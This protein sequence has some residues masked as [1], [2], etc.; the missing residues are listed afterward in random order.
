M[1]STTPPPPPPPPTPGHTSSLGPL[2]PSSGAASPSPTRHQNGT[3]PGGDQS[4][5]NDQLMAA[6]R[7]GIN[8]KPT[9]TNDR[10][11][12][13][14]IQRSNGVLDENGKGSCDSPVTPAD[15]KAIDVM[16]DALQAELRS[17]L[18][19]KIKRQDMEAG[20]GTK[21]EEIER[22]IEATRSEVQ[23]KVNGPSVS[24]VND[25]PRVENPLKTIVDVIDRERGAVFAN[26]QPSP[27]AVKKVN[28]PATRPAANGIALPTKAP[29]SNGKPTAITISP[30]PWKKSVPVSPA[31]VADS[32]K[33]QSVASSSIKIV[34]T[35]YPSRPEATNGTD[36]SNGLSVKSQTAQSMN[37]PP[38]SPLAVATQTTTSPIVASPKATTVPTTVT[39]STVMFTN[40]VPAASSTLPKAN[41]T[42]SPKVVLSPRTTPAA[43]PGP[44]SKPANG[45][46]YS[47]TLPRVKDT[48]TQARIGGPYAKTVSPPSNPA[49]NR[50]VIVSIG[51]F[52]DSPRPSNNLAKQ[53]E[54]LTIDTTSNG[55]GSSTGGTSSPATPKELL[56]PQVRSGTASIRPSQIRTLTKAGSSVS[57]T[58][59]L[60]TSKPIAKLPVSLLEPVPVL[61]AAAAASPP[62]PASPRGPKPASPTVVTPPANGQRTN[63]F[64]KATKDTKSPLN[65]WNDGSA[66]SGTARKLLISHGR[67]NFTVKRTN[68]R[69]GFDADV[70][71][72]KTDGAVKPV[73]RILTDLEKF[74]QEQDPPQQQQPPNGQQYVSFAKDLS[75][76]PNNYPDVVIVTKTVPN[77]SQAPVD[78]FLATLKDIKIDIGEMKVVNAKDS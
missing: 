54:P 71:D 73:F 5:F 43:S 67:P 49:A 53:M 48:R 34:P 57:H 17:T 46:A 23:L 69:Q 3:S 44:F 18:K 66:A 72:S 19:R 20:D 24:P 29:L 9:K 42:A 27:V 36:K 47:N 22:A 37:T 25:T 78:P 59:I 74:E 33:P 1:I 55:T 7:S 70:P 65:R 14:F 2:T 15:D 4:D 75:K 64:E 76:A 13:G 16:K 10:S 51:S 41:G 26:T 63:V 12:P 8:L 30:T 35:V 56:S 58:D 11:T 50:T 21:N 39:S 40:G 32:V 31:P 45:H 6:I 77:T 52:T 28:G 62:P 38:K 68:S 60:E 61:T